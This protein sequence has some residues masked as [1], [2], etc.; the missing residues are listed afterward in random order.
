MYIVSVEL[1]NIKSHKSA[2]F[3]FERG[4]TAITGANGAGKTTIIEAIAWTLFGF[5]DYNKADFVSRGEK[6]GVVR[7]T[8]ETTDQKIYTIVRD[9]GSG[10]FVFDPTIKSKI[11]TGNDEVVGFLRRILQVEPGTDLKE[12]FQTAIGV[13]QGTFTADFLLSRETRK[14]K[15]DKLLKVEEYRNSAEKLKLTAKY[16]ESKRLEVWEKIVRAETQLETFEAITA[17]QKNLAEKEVSLN[18]ELIELQKK[19]DV[20]KVSLADFDGQKIK[21]NEVSNQ[22]SKLEF[23]INEVNRRKTEREKQVTESQDAFSKQNIVEADFKLYEI[24]NDNLK[25]LQVEQ[26]KRIILQTELQKLEGEFRENSINLNNLREK[27]EVSINAKKEIESI[28]AQVEKFHL[29]ENESKQ[30]FEKLT[31]ARNA[32]MQLENLGKDLTKLRED[33]L[34][35]K[36]DIEVNE[37]KQNDF[38]TQLARLNI[39]DSTFD[40]IEKMRLNVSQNLANLKA[41]IEKDRQ[42]EQQV[43]NGLCPILTQKCLNMGEGENLSTYFKNAFSSNSN[44]ISDLT[45]EKTNLEKAQIF[46]REIDNFTAKLEN[47]KKL[48]E[49]TTEN[50]KRLKEEESRLHNLAETVSVFEREANEIENK[51]KTLGNPI[52]REK[53]LV[54]EAAKETIL[55]EQI[56]KLDTQLKQIETDKIKLINDLKQFTDLDE[57]LKTAQSEVERTQFAQKVFLELQGLANLLKQR[58]S[59][60]EQSKNEVSKLLE[61]FETTKKQSVELFSKY[62]ETQHLAE[63]EN[64]NNL[65]KNEAVLETEVRQ[66]IELK[67]QRE[68]EI[69]RLKEIEDKLIVEKAEESKLKKVIEATTFISDTLKKAAPEV[70][71]MLLARISQEAN[72][73]F[74]EMTG[75]AERTLSWKEDYEVSL[76]ES[77]HE[78]PFSTLSGGEQMSAALS[79]RLALLQEL[80]DIRFAFFD[81]PTTN[82]DAE[83]REKLALAINGIS[84]K[85]RFSQIFVISHDDTF[86]SHTDYVISV[87]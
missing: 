75:N 82:L 70:A 16:T 21:I 73:F 87:K 36:N 77:G 59:D 20:S 78:R 85:L 45:T 64:L 35:G 81:E 5:L 51:K 39:T 71:K 52:E 86:E 76:E 80:S 58:E 40:S 31:I 84:Q 49:K 61:E 62:I 57:S 38:K 9:T 41:T 66:T 34:K 56:A 3:D 68:K 72:L 37:A 50:G 6:K 8:V 42:F 25:K 14:R 11:F 19:I 18:K 23:Q 33:F 69:I 26:N 47:A 53:L 48:H 79:V 43:E 24:A 12:L 74:R 67:Q 15:F 13:P 27:H 55:S 2:T 22:I 17:E 28:S 44:K 32:K 4:T 54:F 60:F 46:A 1:E 63:R 30:I 7:V 83:R 10:Y 65:G 29:L